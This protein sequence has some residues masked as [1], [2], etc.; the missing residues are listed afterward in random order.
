MVVPASNVGHIAIHAAF[1]QSVINEETFHTAQ[2]ARLQFE[3]VAVTA[4]LWQ[5]CECE[6]LVRSLTNDIAIHL[7]L[8]FLLTQ[9]TDIHVLHLSVSYLYLDVSVFA[10]R[11]VATQSDAT[12]KEWLRLSSCGWFA[13]KHIVG[14]TILG[15]HLLHIVGGTTIHLRTVDVNEVARPV[16]TV[17]VLEERCIAR[18]LHHVAV[19]LHTHDESRLTQCC[20]E[21]ASAHTSI[22]GIL[23]HIDVVGTRCIVEEMVVGKEEVWVAIPVRIHHVLPRNLLQQSVGMAERVDKDDVRILS[24]QTLEDVVEVGDVLR[25]DILVTN[26]HI[27]QR[28][29]CWMSC[30]RTHLRPAVRGRVCQGIVDGIAEVLNHSVHVLRTAH[31]VAVTHGTRHTGI[32]HEHGIHAQV[33]AELQELVVAHAPSG[34]I[35]PHVPFSAT[36]HRV[37]KCL[38]PFHTVLVCGSL[39]DA[40]TWPAHEARVQIHEHL[41]HVGTLSVLASLERV[42]REERHVINQHCSCLVEFQRQFSFH[43]SLTCSQRGCQ[44]GPVLQWLL[45]KGNC[46]KR[47][48]RLAIH[49]SSRDAALVVT[50]THIEAQVVFLASLQ[51]HAPVACIR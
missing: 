28:E 6:L 32:V 5:L 38:L 22:A 3:G 7:P 4:E 1:V 10:L 13:H 42:L 23:T 14:R 41:C 35:A 36:S 24:L 46:A 11:G 40:A 9:V 12:S 50:A 45:C 15:C 29:W 27:F 37:A 49:Q 33:L 18:H 43:G 51:A 8:T 2:F 39:H 20:Q 17:L 34:A 21:I 26:L 25:T 30:L 47:L 44:F 31:E 16:A 19:A 48:A